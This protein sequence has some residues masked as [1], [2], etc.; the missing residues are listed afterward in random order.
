MVYLQWIFKKAMLSENKRRTI[1]RKYLEKNFGK[2]MN[3]PGV[4]AG[5]P[6]ELWRDYDSMLPGTNEA[7]AF[8]VIYA[9]YV[10]GSHKRVIA[11]SDS[12]EEMK[13]IVKASFGKESVAAGCPEYDTYE[14]YKVVFD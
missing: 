3:V 8:E 1:A 11:V 5:K 4:F 6:F 7:R 10:S 12:I 2:Q 9:P 13:E 14:G